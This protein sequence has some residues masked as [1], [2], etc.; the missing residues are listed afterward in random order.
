MRKMR[1]I[2]FVVLFFLLIGAVFTIAA[3]SES[4]VLTGA[5]HCFGVTPDAKDENGSDGWDI[6]APEGYVFSDAKVKAGPDCYGDGE[7]YQ[8]TGIGTNHVT[9]VML[10]EEGP[11]CHE[12]SHLEGMWEEEPH[13]YCE[14][15]V[16]QEGT[17]SDW[18]PHPEDEGWECHS[19]WD[20]WVDA[21]YPD[22]LCDTEEV[23]ECREI[24]P[25]VCLETI[26]VYGEWSD[27]Y[28][29]PEDETQECHSAN[30]TYVDAADESRICDTGVEEVCRAI[31]Q[32]EEVTYSISPICAPKGGFGK[33]KVEIFGLLTFNLV[34]DGFLTESGIFP[35][36]PVGEYSYFVEVGE[37]YTLVGEPDGTFTI[38]WCP[39]PPKKE[40]PTGAMDLPFFLPGILVIA[41]G[42]TLWFLGRRQ[43]MI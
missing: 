26:P 28:P 13:V 2:S 37:G 5:G 20:V 36:L 3:A 17:W 6:Y 14:E 22:Y 30:I 25:E 29:H 27:W 15:T 7:M 9:A 38:E 40:P 35:D 21:E 42:G 41:L 1:N 32:P 8:I 16:Y 33:L 34:D 24:P 11:E 39:S 19:R 12:I 4:P 31:P 10:C 23:I 18:Y 43:K